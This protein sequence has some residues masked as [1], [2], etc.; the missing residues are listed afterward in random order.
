MHF[1]VNNDQND[2]K[3]FIEVLYKWSTLTLS[4]KI[5]RM[6]LEQYMENRGTVIRKEKEN[7]VKR[8]QDSPKQNIGL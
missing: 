2:E 4:E 3:T 8:Q 1:I 5:N 7:V 6:D